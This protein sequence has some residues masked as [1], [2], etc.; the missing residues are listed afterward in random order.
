MS[1]N[2][3]MQLLQRL[4]RTS[5]GTSHKSAEP[6]ARKAYGPHAHS[7]VVISLANPVCQ[8]YHLADSNNKYGLCKVLPNDVCRSSEDRKDGKASQALLSCSFPC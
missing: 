6:F 4:D 7:E 8:F 2:K 5:C 3:A 1:T